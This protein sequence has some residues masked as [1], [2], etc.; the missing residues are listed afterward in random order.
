MA[1]EAVICETPGVTV[2]GTTE[3]GRKAEGRRAP[4]AELEGALKVI[5]ALAER[6]TERVN[7]AYPQLKQ[8]EQRLLRAHE[9]RATVDA[10]MCSRI[11]QIRQL[12]DEIVQELRKFQELETMCVRETPIGDIAD[13]EAS[14]DP[15]QARRLR[16]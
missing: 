9:Q 8:L 16:A 7:Q 5:R 1:K 6:V 4:A 12:T 15:E 2:S 13:L 14:S 3:E 11:T 10:A